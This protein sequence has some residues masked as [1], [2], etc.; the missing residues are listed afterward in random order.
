MDFSSM[1]QKTMKDFT[2][3]NP[4]FE[5]SQNDPAAKKKKDT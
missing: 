2:P 5:P 3:F 4:F 1:A